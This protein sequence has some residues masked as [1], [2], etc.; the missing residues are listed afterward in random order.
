M[1]RSISND[2][3]SRS[4]LSTFSS[5]NLLVSK[6][7]TKLFLND[8]KADVYFVFDFDG[9]QEK[10]PAHSF[11]LVNA[12]E[13]FDCMFDEKWANRGTIEIT[14][15]SIGGFKEF[16]Q[17]F[18]KD[19][20]KI[21]TENLNEVMNLANKYDVIDC[22][23][24]CEKF[25]LQSLSINYICTGLEAAILFE[26]SELKE[27]CKKKIQQFPEVVIQ[28]DDILQCS[29]NVLRFILKIDHLNCEQGKLFDTCMT[30]AMNECER[31]GIDA[32]I[33]T[34]RKSVLGDCLDLIRF[35]LMDPIEIA[36]YIA[37]Y[38]GL[39]NNDELENIFQG[40]STN[41]LDSSIIA[42]IPSQIQWNDYFAIKMYRNC[43][44]MSRIWTCACKLKQQNSTLF[45]VNKAII[46]GELTLNFIKSDRMGIMEALMTI[47]EM[48]LNRSD[49][50]VL[51]V[52]RIST[53][54]TK[55]RTL[56]QNIEPLSKPLLLLPNKIYEIL[57]DFEQRPEKCF[58]KK[59]RK[60]DIEIGDYKVS[61]LK[62][63]CL[64]IASLHF[65]AI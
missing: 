50:K 25:V 19:E 27:H 26:R 3:N 38:K 23:S 18:Y 40:I 34:N 12:S 31:K 35:D 20:V 37:K 21:T 46:F 15:A 45:Y 30:W 52:Q 7:C 8:T 65:N 16:L 47:T 28:S 62:N 6:T 64:L 42:K 17:F 43:D 10:V 2:A 4:N 49:D 9:K 1:D 60:E 44:L 57:I 59:S 61:F 33:M 11:L 55:N 22:F 54:R 5:N 13:V 24:V 36:Q 51:L 41:K 53:Q 32:N 39:F 63:D 56:V 58:A 48:E 29:I 14:D